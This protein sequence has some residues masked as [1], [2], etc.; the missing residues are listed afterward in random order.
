MRMYRYYRK[1]AMSEEEAI[2][3]NKRN[4][5]NSRYPLYAVTVE[6]EHAKEF[7]HER[8]MSK[9]FKF[10]SDYDED[11]EDEKTEIQKYLNR[12]R[13]CIIEPYPLEAASGKHTR[14]EKRYTVTMY[15]TMN[16]KQE[17]Q[18]M[19]NFL[20][21]PVFWKDMPSAYVF[22]KDFKDALNKLRYE[23]QRKLFTSGNY[24]MYIADLDYADPGYEYDELN[25]FIKI[26]GEYLNPK[27]FK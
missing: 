27:F 26:F 11:D 10:T 13:G 1:D 14:K 24:A 16:E 17:V 3:R 6:K 5:I 4:D 9:Y 12:H 19:T 8:D 2:A 7:E 22:R 25:I 23:D 15:I 20:Q 21:D 18:E